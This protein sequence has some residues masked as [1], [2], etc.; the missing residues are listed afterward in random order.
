MG[1]CE[2]SWHCKYADILK[3]K[4]ELEGVILFMGGALMDIIRLE[5][6][7]VTLLTGA[8]ARFMNSGCSIY[9]FRFT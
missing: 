9:G 4:I 3:L 8:L 5:I 7:W 1:S 2:F 6:G